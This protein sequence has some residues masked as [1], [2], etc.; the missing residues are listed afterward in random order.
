MSSTTD[1]PTSDYD[2]V[3]GAAAVTAVVDAFY[4]KVL[5]DRDLVHHFEGVDLPRL[6]QHQVA[7]VSQ[8]MGGPAA[9]SGRSLQ[10]A[11]ARL[12]VTGEEFA[13]VAA[14]LQ[15]ALV[16]AGVPADIVERTLAAV[17]ATRSDIVA[18]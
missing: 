3:G 18:G 4:G 7:L 14:H 12:A 15:G 1:A 2:A 10:A 11:H 9:Y 6:K 16:D 17:G 5:A 13:R 8:V